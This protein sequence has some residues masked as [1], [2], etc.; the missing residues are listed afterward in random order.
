MQPKRIYRWTE[1]E[2]VFLKF[3]YP[4]KDFTQEEILQ[5]LPN[6]TKEAIRQKAIELGLKPY[7]PPKP[8]QGYKKCSACGTI[9][10]LTFFHRDKKSKD[11]LHC[12]CRIC[13]LEGTIKRKEQNPYTQHPEAHKKG[14]YLQGLVYSSRRQG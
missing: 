3:A 5:A 13:R 8:P 9:L 10:P 2:V 14:L 6:R 7:T 1:E 11:G 12:Q 4:N